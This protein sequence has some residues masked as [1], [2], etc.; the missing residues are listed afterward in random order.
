MEIETEGVTSEHFI[1]HLKSEAKRVWELYQNG[2]IREFYFR[3]DR[4]EAVWVLESADAIDARQRLESLPL[5]KAGLIT[6]DIIPF[7]PDPG[8]TRLFGGLDAS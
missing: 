3:E 8:L 4:S 1:P 5:V 7:V 6:F 2:T